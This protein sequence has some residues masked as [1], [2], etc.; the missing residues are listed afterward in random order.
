MW[1]QS[2]PFTVTIQAYDCEHEPQTNALNW[3]KWTNRMLNH[4]CYVSELTR[5]R[6]ER[7]GRATGGLSASGTEAEEV[8]NV[9]GEWLPPRTISVIQKDGVNYEGQQPLAAVHP[10]LET[11]QREWGVLR[12]GALDSQWSCDKMLYSTCKTR[13]LINEMKGRVWE[14]F[15]WRLLTRHSG[16]DSSRASLLTPPLSS[17]A[18]HR[19]FSQALWPPAW[20][21]QNAWF[22]S[23]SLAS[24]LSSALTAAT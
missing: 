17:R 1:W 4:H 16:R 15:S 2:F 12:S 19:A 6:V 3:S 24:E 9:G 22:S 23:L 10:H 21:I 11:G 14:F 18:V 5:V 13:I 8:P 7:C 20:G